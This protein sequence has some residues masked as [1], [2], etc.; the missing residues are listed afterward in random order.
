MDGS[1]RSRGVAGDAHKPKH[2]PQLPKIPNR[3]GRSSVASIQLESPNV[4]HPRKPDASFMRSNMSQQQQPFGGSNARFARGS[5]AQVERLPDH[6]SRGGPAA[7]QK[8][9]PVVVY[10]DEGIDVTP[11]SLLGPVRQ[12]PA[13]HRG[14]NDMSVAE[15]SIGRE[16][17]QDALNNIESMTVGSWKTSVF[18]GKSAAQGAGGLSFSSKI[19]AVS[20]SERDED[21]SSMV[22]A[23]S[24]DERGEA[25]GEL[26]GAKTKA[27]EWSLLRATRRV[28][29]DP[30]QRLNIVLTETETI[31]LLDIPSKI[32]PSESEEAIQVKADNARYKEI[33]V[34]RP[35]SDNF[36]DRST[37]T[38]NNALKTKDVQATAVRS[39]N[40]DCQ[41]NIW[42]IADA[43]GENNATNDQRGD[44]GDETGH[45]ADIDALPSADF[46]ASGPLGSHIQSSTIA[47]SVNFAMGTRHDMALASSM[48]GGASTAGMSTYMGDPES[49]RASYAGGWNDAD[50]NAARETGTQTH[51]QHA[52]ELLATM[53]RA[54]V[55][56]NY[57]KR[58]M[59]YRE[60][61]D[62]EDEIG[63]QNPNAPGRP[64]R[65]GASQL[66]LGIPTTLRQAS[67]IGGSRV[68]ANHAHSLTDLPADIPSLQLLWSFRCELTRGRSVNYIAWNGQNQNV[69]AIA[70]GEAKHNP[71]AAPGLIL[72]WS[73]KNPEWP[74]RIYPAKSP[75]TALDFSNAN[76]C[77]LAAGYMDG[78]IAVYDV[79]IKDIANGMVL[80]SSEV[81][82]KHRDPVWELKWIERERAVGDGNSRGEILVSVSTDG[83]VVQWMIRKGLECSNLMT[84]KRVSEKQEVKAG[85]PT[86]NSGFMARH[87]GGLC[88][89][90]HPT[91][92]SMYIVGTED[93][94]LHKC[95]TSYHEQY[96]STFSGHQGPVYRVRW[97]PFLP[98]CFLS[99]SADWTVRLWNQES[100]DAPLKFQNGKEAVLDVAWSPHASTVFGCVSANGRLEV[101]DLLFSGLDPAITHPVLDRQLTTVSFSPI[102]PAILTGDDNGAAYVYRLKNLPSMSMGGSMQEQGQRLQEVMTSKTSHLPKMELAPAAVV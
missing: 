73:L 102:T 79:R 9:A 35:S 17:V 38:L 47:E 5:H 39:V 89:D 40:A 37:Q 52:S 29:A 61:P 91:D 7:A 76:P 6:T 15:S 36:V 59:S 41:V 32:V 74:E 46:G 96:L 49:G 60:V 101:W 48:M 16:S 90:F 98:S 88:F 97:S 63:S 56:N 77:L 95:S 13:R 78:R 75:V 57:L 53:E 19:S 66:A 1:T 2:P 72:C 92:N 69:L 62:I 58:L 99:C 26:A 28:E 81:A 45:E 11:V 55:G 34:A 94:C 20:D 44:G 85:S 27:S 65:G 30:E 8:N 21:S 50:A 64:L 4:P 84:L 14:V 3:S 82:G 67:A 87:S 23:D 10:D 54:V 51:Q 12:Q 18:A 22:S 31:W 71:D 24:D 100:P 33:K 83:R 42:S 80:D 70:Y 93:G 86:R 43:M 25:G 68:L